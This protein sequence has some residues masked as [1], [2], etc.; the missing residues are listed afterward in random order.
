[1]SV[2]RCTL[3]GRLGKAVELRYTKSGMAVANFSIATSDSY[4]DKQ[5]QK[6]ENTEWHKIVIWGKLGETANK[7]L[8][9][10]MEV[11][12][13]GKLQTRMWEKDGHKN[14]TTEIVVSTMKFI[15]NRK[16]TVAVDQSQKQFEEAPVAEQQQL[17]IGEEDVPF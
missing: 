12:L 6:V 13:E 5:G 10:G 1:M 7:Y 2:N 4:T 17:A 8:E 14:Y 15:G 16:Q 9:K 3:V 11:Y